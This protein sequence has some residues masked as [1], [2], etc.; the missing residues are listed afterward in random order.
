MTCKR[1]IS[2]CIFLLAVLCSQYSVMAAID[3]NNAAISAG[4][5]HALMIKNNGSLWAWG[6][7]VHGRLGNGMISLFDENWDF[8]PDT[9]KTAPVKIMDSVAFGGSATRSVKI[10]VRVASFQST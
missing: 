10:T 2:A 4:E 8:K 3:T 9:D 1:I 6:N 7:N 5:F